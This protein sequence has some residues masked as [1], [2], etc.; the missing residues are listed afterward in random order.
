MGNFDVSLGGFI[1]SALRSS[2]PLL[3][4]LLGEILTQRV[5]VVNLGVEGQM[6]M[7]A[8]CGFGATLA[9]GNPWLGIAAGCAAGMILS[10]LHALL[11]V[12]LKAN[13]FA[14]GLAV[15][16]IG[17]GLSAF[18]GIPLVG[19]KI[20]GLNALPLRALAKIPVIG[21][22]ATQITPTVALA[23]VASPLIGFWLY[24]TRTGLAW[25]A[26]GESLP[27]SKALGIKTSLVQVGGVLAGGFLSG[28]GGAAL[29]VDYTRNWV[30]G[31][32]AGRGLVAVG[33]VIVA[34]WNPFLAV[35]AA[36]LFGG[37]EALTLRM[38][39]SGVPISSHLLQ[40]LPY[41]ASLAV[42]V[43]SY[44]KA[45]R[46]GGTPAGLSAVFAKSQ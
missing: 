33:L 15:W 41:L 31:M 18:Y 14:S 37:A 5:A 22:I 36:L 25:R 16:M 29:S 1:L 24:R 40:T 17:F 20:V 28:L 43:L 26:V 6:L 7:G 11:C 19:Q 8:L 12:G 10:G 45:N 2:T 27:S 13:Q 38:Q 39:T 21:T 9:T 4:V 3:W 44:R 32:T 35:P 23:I 34:R 46:E 30:E 42:L